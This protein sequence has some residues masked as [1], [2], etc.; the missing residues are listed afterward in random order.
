[1][2]SGR[3]GFLT[4]LAVGVSSFA[5][6]SACGGNVP[7]GPT[8]AQG[9]GSSRASAQL[10]IVIPVASRTASAS[11]RRPAYVSPSTASVS[12]TVDAG[13]PVVTN[14]SAS[15]PA[16]SG[17]GPL[18]P[19]DCNVPISASAGTHTLTI[20]TYDGANA[21][22]NK[23]SSNDVAAKIVAGQAN[24]I[25]V[26]LGGVPAEVTIGSGPV[27]TT[28]N[29]GNDSLV[30]AGPLPK[31]M[32]VE[33]L[34]ADAN[35]IVGPGAPTLSV[36]SNPAIVTAVAV[37]TVGGS[38]QTT[39]EFIVT[40]T[41]LGTTSLTLTAT[42]S[43][44]GGSTVAAA[45]PTIVSPIL[46]VANTGASDTSSSIT[47]YAPWS[48]SP[49]LTITNGISNPIALAAGALGTLYVLDGPTGALPN[50][51]EAYSDG[52]TT[53][54]RTITA[55]LD[56]PDAIVVDQKN[57]TLY[58]ANATNNTIT[59]YAANTTAVLRTI[60]AA[61]GINGPAALAID[62]SENLYVANYTGNTVTEYAP[63]SIVP[64]R[65]IATGVSGPFGLAINALTGTVFVANLTA[66]DIT[67]YTTASGLAPAVTFTGTDFADATPL[68][69]PETPIGI[70]SNARIY[71]A[72]NAAAPASITTY[73]LAN[74]AAPTTDLIT[75]DVNLPL[76]VALD[77]TNN[78]YVANQV[79]TI[80]PHGTITVYAGG[81]QVNTRTLGGTLGLVYGPTAI[82]PIG[83]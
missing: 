5:L 36:T 42:Q 13:T 34:D 70:D 58:V 53:I 72:N 78:L 56:G 54:S 55:G 45:V 22:G 66:N 3:Y 52:G 73:T 65:T 7:A 19:L 29:G 67:A 64:L 82:L 18:F 80:N 4:T 23:L 41:A 43:I 16:C 21:T 39:N 25:G 1:M 46:G 27:E 81:G 9:Q 8:A 10:R 38:A 11:K 59:E 48:A 17:A 35:V 28:A 31:T 50:T 40:P 57:G 44:T 74:G 49:A 47:E 32:I 20:V 6:L 79:G 60:P 76:A 37:P 14:L 69:T 62:G 51:I 15:S 12:V 77:N 63:G 83:P 33:A 24:I 30:F 2:R 75:S 61:N 26:T 68:T 71:A